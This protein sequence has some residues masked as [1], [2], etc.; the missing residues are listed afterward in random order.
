MSNKVSRR[1]VLKGVGAGLGGISLGLLGGA[2]ALAQ[3]PQPQPDGATLVS[4]PASAP[5]QAAEPTPQPAAP[6]AP[7]KQPLASYRFNI[8]NFDAWVIKD[9][10]VSLPATILGANV[11]E[12]TLR[13]F[14]DGR[15]VLNPDGTFDAIVQ[16]LVVNTG[17]NIVVFDTG[18]GPMVPSGGL[19]PATLMQNGVSPTQVDTV[20]ISHWHGDHVGGLF[21]LEGGLTFP[22]AR[23]YFPQPEWDF[24]QSAREIPELDEAVSA[25]RTN[26]ETI[27]EMGMLNFYSD[28]QRPVAGVQAIH[29]PGHTPGHMAFLIESA[30]DRLM[31]I[32]DA[33]LSTYAGPANPDWYAGFDADGPA[34]AA[35]RRALFARLAAERIKMFGYH[36]SYPGVGYINPVGDTGSYVFTPFAF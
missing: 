14:L 26:L 21:T 29:T 25:T 32:V 7:A 27:A 22:N 6:P 16:I 3:E 15:Y 2:T 19:L 9:G 13:S 11:D 30:G 36:Y 8:G 4:V 20:F 10:G 12:A 5:Q 28:G 1:S 23:H 18:L 35:T 33:S 24:L 34:A 31:N 17:S